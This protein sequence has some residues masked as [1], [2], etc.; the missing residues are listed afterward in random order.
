MT[1][2]SITE[3]DD[4]PHGHTTHATERDDPPHGLTTPATERDVLLHSI[5]TLATTR[6]IGA[7]PPSTNAPG[8]PCPDIRLTET[9]ASPLAQAHANAL[10]PPLGPIVALALL[11]TFLKASM[12]T[13]TLPKG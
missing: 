4:P 6:V 5:T 8:A 7:L 10:L 9:S 13:T 2:Q 11:Q 3:R 12:S 1:S